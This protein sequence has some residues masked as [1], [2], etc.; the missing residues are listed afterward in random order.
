[1]T[2]P[3]HTVRMPEHPLLPLRS[4]RLPADRALYPDP[5]YE[6]GRDIILPCATAASWGGPA[7]SLHDGRTRSGR[8]V[9]TYP[10][11]SACALP[12][13]TAPDAGGTPLPGLPWGT[14]VQVRLGARHIWVPLVEEITPAH[15]MIPGSIYLTPSAVADL[16]GRELDL[17]APQWWTARVSVVI[18]DVWMHLTDYWP[19]G[20]P[21]G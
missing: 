6:A 7:D 20:V 13:A 9:D 5:A 1:M 2:T 3:S 18:P 11:L 10:L 17:S 8:R 12:L 14:R 21:R 19:A 4:R 16:T 15:L